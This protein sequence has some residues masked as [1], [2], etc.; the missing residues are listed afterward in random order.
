MKEEGEED[1]ILMEDQLQLLL[2][3]TEADSVVKCI[4]ISVTRCFYRLRQ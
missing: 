1:P 2:I 3:P 4:S